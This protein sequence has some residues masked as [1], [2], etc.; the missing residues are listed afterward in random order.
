M[1]TSDEQTQSQSS[2]VEP[3]VDIY[4][5]THIPQRDRDAPRAAAMPDGPARV[6]EHR[7][8]ELVRLD[9]VYRE[10]L[11]Q[12]QFG[13]RRGFRLIRPL[14][15]GGQG[16]VF[17]TRSRGADGFSRAVAL[18]VF[19]P[20]PYG[21]SDD[22]ARAMRRIASV[23][24]LVARGYH[25]HLVD[26][27][28]FHKRDGIRV[29]LME[30]IDGYDLRRLLHLRLL[31]QFRNRASSEEW[32]KISNVVVAAGPEQSL[33]H[34]G[35]AIT[36]IRDCL[37]GL[38]ILHRMG[39]LHGDLKP[40]NVMLRRSGRAKIIDFGSAV[41]LRDPPTQ[42][43]FTPAYAAPEVLTAKRW[44]PQSD[45]ASL[46]Y[47]VVELLAGRRLFPF[48]ES[49]KELL[50]RKHAL[51]DRLPRLLPERVTRSACLMEF[52]HRLVATDPKDRFMSANQADL[53]PNHGAYA[54]L[55]ELA[56]SKLDAEWRNDLGIWVDRLRG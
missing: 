31:R 42:R 26:V 21:Q 13:G 56:R 27:Q 33:L 45:L 36:I 50:D 7:A 28:R 47:V 25:D 52:L 46:G 54:F 2:A 17:L 10:I 19:S 1:S 44:T 23:V 6:D 38:K 41:M 51:P 8:A 9:E 48:R 3:S 29:M 49:V 37:E 16:K 40:A 53:D 11:N 14:G 39:I 4:H 5:S 18:K 43:V 30:W 55:Q 15:K 22:Y 32:E 24:S 35:A 34:P 12:K 20:E